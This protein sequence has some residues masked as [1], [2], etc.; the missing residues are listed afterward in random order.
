MKGISEVKDG[1]G[2]GEISNNKG[3]NQD[4]P[5]DRGV[6]YLFCWVE[7]EICGELIGLFRISFLGQPV[8][9]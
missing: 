2:R 9:V 6:P 7:F 8:I 3:D 4:T 5:K 1:R